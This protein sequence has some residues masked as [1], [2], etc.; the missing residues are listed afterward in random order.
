MATEEIETEEERNARIAEVARKAREIFA[1]AP[2]EKRC[3][4]CFKKM[5]VEYAAPMFEGDF[6]GW[7]FSCWGCDYESRI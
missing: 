2:S 4:Q 3:P 6:G 1:P 7:V 5:V